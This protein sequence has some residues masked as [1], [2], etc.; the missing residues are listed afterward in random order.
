V[1]DSTRDPRGFC[2]SCVFY[3]E[4]LDENI[5]NVKAGDDAIDYQWFCLDDLPDTTFNHKEILLS[6]IDSK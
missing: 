2:I 6:I 1:G 5:L 4:I 3:G